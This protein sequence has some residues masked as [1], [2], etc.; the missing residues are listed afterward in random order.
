MSD[1]QGMF[2]RAAYY[3]LS[4]GESPRN[5][6]DGIAVH[7]LPDRSTLRALQRDLQRVYDDYA[8]EAWREHLSRIARAY[9]L[10]PRQ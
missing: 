9:K 2:D 1:A 10:E 6:L 8:P 7:A 3:M 5:A 4:R